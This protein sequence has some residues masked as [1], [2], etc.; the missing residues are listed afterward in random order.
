[1]THMLAHI[2][3]D[4]CKNFIEKVP[5]S[6]YNHTSK[7]SPRVLQVTFHKKFA[8]IGLI[9]ERYFHVVQLLLITKVF[10]ARRVLVWMVPKICLTSFHSGIVP[11]HVR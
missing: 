6:I 5:T 7:Y 8:E 4:A 10:T 3:A 11:N 2:Y 9:Q 1:M